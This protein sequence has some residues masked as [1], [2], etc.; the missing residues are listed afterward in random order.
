MSTGYDLGVDLYELWRAGSVVLPDVA[1]QFTDAA[2]LLDP[3]GARGAFHRTGGLG[4]GGGAYGAF[5]SWHSLAA[6]LDGFL[7]ET[8][9]NLRDTG[10]ALVMIADDYAA[11]DAEAQRELDRRR[12]EIGG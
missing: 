11:T 12:S 9:T 4:A 7:N 6:T 8:A 3:Q 5:T 1:T 10:R 2:A